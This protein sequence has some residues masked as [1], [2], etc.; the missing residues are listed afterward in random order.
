MQ[1]VVSVC[2][3]VCVGC[4]GVYVCVYMCGW[5]YVCVQVC[6]YVIPVPFL[7]SLQ[8]LNAGPQ[9]PMGYNGSA[10]PQGPQGEAG[11]E[12]VGGVVNLSNYC[13][14]MRWECDLEGGSCDTDG[15]VAPVSIPALSTHA[16][17]SGRM[18]GGEYLTGDMQSLANLFVPV[19]CRSE[20]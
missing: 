14:T 1:L 3:C 4:V 15:A 6:F 8:G 13:H 2:V 11:P 17:T 10:G 20:V 18:E 12:A 16:L 5:V 9:G 7:L 19:M